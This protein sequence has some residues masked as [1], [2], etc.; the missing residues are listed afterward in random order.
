MADIDSLE[1]ELL[2]IHVAD[3][4]ALDAEAVPF[5][6]NSKLKLTP[7][8]AKRRPYKEL[9][10]KDDAPPYTVRGYVEHGYRG[11]MTY[12][13]CVKTLFFIHNETGNIYSHVIAFVLTLTVLT[14]HFFTY[15]LKNAELTLQDTIFCM[16]FFFAA[17][18]CFAAS[19]M[20]HTFCCRSVSSFLTF[21]TYDLLGIC[22]FILAQFYVGLSFGYRCH[23]EIG[24]VY[25][26]IISAIAL[27]G[28]IAPHI[29]ALRER[30]VVTNSIYVGFVVFSVVPICHWIVLAGW[31]S[32]EVKNF[33]WVLFGVLACYACG[34]VF[35]IFQIP[36]RLA[37]GK[38]DIWGQSHTLWH[39]FVTAGAFMFYFCGCEFAI[40]RTN[41]PCG[42]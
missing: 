7:S 34:F 5:S 11:E 35:F 2:E 39:I 36:E 22:L 42:A 21:Y 29:Q 26:G 6:P 27:A 20:Y 24:R 12:F 8:T 25:M 14:T 30:P 15:V 16:V 40:W 18:Y 33:A 4:A 38:F 31:G 19:S 28:L 9:L 23:P 32:D 41:H 13:E 10:S 1:T 37:P 17:L 3:S